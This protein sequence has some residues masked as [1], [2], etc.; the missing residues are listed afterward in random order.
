MGRRLVDSISSQYIAAANMLRPKKA[1]KKI[2]AYVESYDDIFF[3]RT[4]LSEFE[5]DEFYF[6]VMLPSSD[7]LSRG[8]KIALMNRL[9]SGLGQ[10]MIACVDADYDYLMQGVG[11]ASRQLMNNPYVFHTYAYAIEN[12]Q[13]YAESLHQV[14]VM[15]TLNDRSLIDIPAFIHLYSRIVHPLF[16]WSVWSYRKNIYDKFSI[17]EFNAVARLGNVNLSHPE[18]ALNEL[19][20]RVRRKLHWLERRYSRFK[21]EVAAMHKEFVSLGVTPDSTYLFIQGH[22]LMENVVLK[23]LT[24]ICNQLRREREHEIKL[25]AEHNTQMQNELTCYQN[26]QGNI[27]FMLRKNIAYKEAP[28]YQRIRNDIEELLNKLKGRKEN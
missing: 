13:C 9:G 15:A 21:G 3:W 25:L 27:E 7:S 18:S 2:V 20:E 4:L 8:K 11:H 22:H 1:R 26:S 10:N 5:D 19:A 23:L 14:C 6:Q 16:I 12:Y 24:P 17:T 28:T